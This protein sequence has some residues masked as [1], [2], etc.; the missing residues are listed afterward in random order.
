MCLWP[1]PKYSL[2]RVPIPTSHPS[3]LI[4]GSELCQDV[5]RGGLWAGHGL[6]IC[7]VWSPGLASVQLTCTTLWNFIEKLEFLL[8]FE[9]A[10]NRT[11]LDA[12][13]FVL[14]SARA[15]RWLPSLGCVCVLSSPLAVANYFEA[16]SWIHD[17]FLF[18][19]RGRGI[20]IC[21]Q[22]SIK[23]ELTKES[24][25]A[26]GWFPTWIGLCGHLSLSFVLK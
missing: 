13:S 9:E 23:G 12:Y 10:G 5:Q 26:T 7:F 24:K 6:Q 22:I 20:F 2:F 19:P 21:A 11:A 18:C 1:W 16:S 3:A 4:P 14:Q 15:K 17:C 8:S 25:K